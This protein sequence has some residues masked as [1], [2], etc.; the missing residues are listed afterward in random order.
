MML[1]NMAFS[2]D[3]ALNGIPPETKK[4]RLSG[5]AFVELGTASLAVAVVD[6]VLCAVRDGLN[7]LAGAAHGV[8]GRH[9]QAATDQNHSH[10]LAKHLLSPV[11]G[12]A[13]NA[14]TAIKFIS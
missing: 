1:S 13:T 4:P 9:H 7:V 12:C 6:R 3:S 2:P 5:G 10:D 11:T 8:A 14:E